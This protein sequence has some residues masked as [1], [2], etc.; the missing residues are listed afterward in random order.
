MKNTFVFML[1]LSLLFPAARLQGQVV[2][3]GQVTAYNRFPLKNVLVKAKKSKVEVKTDT[4]GFFRI[5]LNEKD[6]LTFRADGFVPVRIKKYNDHMQVNMVFSGGEKNKKIAVGKGYI[7]EEDMTYAINN[8][9]DENNDFA[10]YR[11][12]FDLIKGQFAGVQVIGD[13]ILIRGQGSINLSTQPLFV[14]DGMKVEDISWISP[15]EVK[16]LSILKDASASLYGARGATGVII[17]EMKKK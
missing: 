5:P 12:I 9:S 11:T 1:S 7:S 8:L 4:N 15:V 2:A 17:I 13:Q 10:K 3:A 14:V 16:S 6:V